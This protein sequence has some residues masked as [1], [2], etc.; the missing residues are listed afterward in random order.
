[1]PCLGLLSLA[2]LA[3]EW[4]RAGLRVAAGW[5]EQGADLRPSLYRRVLGADYERLSPAG[6]VLHDAGAKAWTGRCT[7]DG[8]QTMAGR[9]VAWLFQLPPPVADAPVAVDFTVAGGG[10]LWT[11]H[12]GG[13][14]MRSRQYIGCRKPRGWVIEQFGPFA[15]DLELP[16]AD[17]GRLSQV[18]RGAR[19]LGVPLPRFLWPYC[20]SSEF[21]RD[22]CY[23]F[24]VMIGLP[25]AGR[26]V[27]YRGWLKDR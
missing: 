12:I 4:R 14:A 13:R 19:C 11:R 24:D 17:D 10:E 21:E 16:L 18:I 8:P 15:F 2:D 1:M 25:L 3:A 7:V 26:L 27:R 22:G 23:H 6:R 9:L 5:G 20:E